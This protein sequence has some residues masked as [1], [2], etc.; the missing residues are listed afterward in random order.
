MWKC[1]IHHANKIDKY[2]Q[3]YKE[4][5]RRESDWSDCSNPDETLY[6]ILPYFNFCGS[7]TRYNLFIA[8]VE[9]I[10]KYE[11]I[12]I[13]ISEATTSDK[14]D[15]P[16]NINGIFQH[17]GY[18]LNNQF[19]C[20][21]NLINLAIAELP[22]NWKYVAW[23]DADITFLNDNWVV[24]AINKLKEYNFIQLFQTAVYMGPANEAIKIDNSFGYMHQASKQEWRSDHKYGFWHCGFAW[25]CNRYAY[26]KT[27][28]LID[29]SILG[30]GDH[31]MALSLIQKVELS[32]PNNPRLHPAFLARLKNYEALVKI[33]K[34]SLSYIDGTI[35][36]HWHGRLEDRKYI[37]RWEIFYEHGYNPD[38]D[39]VK[40]EKGLIDLT[41]V[42]TRM[43]EDL[44]IYFIE[45]N[46]DGAEL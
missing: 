24:D 16:N 8:F 20:K 44:E 39:I 19:W 21:E 35:L 41:D 14:Y 7:T 2:V 25:A 18:K 3:N 15:L 36:H 32:C 5:E 30:S 12:K 6:V 42:G 29:F 31:H 26:D 11:N 22:R 34:L 27:G 10:R 23:I 40:N 46:E 4:K 17:H 45:R 13:I 28:G 37:E 38:E 33:Y 1:F 43:K 9:H